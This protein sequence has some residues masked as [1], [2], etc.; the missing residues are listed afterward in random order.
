MGGWSFREGQW[1]SFDDLRTY[2]TQPDD[3]GDFARLLRHA[4][5]ESVDK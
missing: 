5:Q 4:R 2:E 3:V 1:V